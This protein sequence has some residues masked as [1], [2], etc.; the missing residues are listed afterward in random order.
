MGSAIRPEYREWANGQATARQAHSGRELKYRNRKNQIEGSVMAQN[1][2]HA[3][4]A[5]VVIFPV[6]SPQVTPI[7]GGVDVTVRAE[8]TRVDQ[9]EFQT[10]DYVLCIDA[11]G[12]EC[13]D[14]II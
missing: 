9:Q 7:T 2:P 10:G 8:I 4:N 13:K 5:N 14:L 6:E 1:A 3:Q 11:Q 12:A